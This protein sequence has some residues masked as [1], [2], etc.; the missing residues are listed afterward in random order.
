MSV[1][2]G[3]LR[4][5]AA[6]WGACF[7]LAVVF[8][9]ATAAALL[10]R[11][12]DH[13]DALSGAPVIMVDLAPMAVSTQSQQLDLAPGP[14][15]T[16]AQ[17]EPEPDTPK[18][19][20]ELLPDKTLDPIPAEKPKT[21]KP[22]EKKP[23]RQEASLTTAPVHTERQA[24]RAQT[25]L[26]G[27]KADSDALPNWKSALVAALERQ[28]RY[29]SEAQSRGEYGVA[30]LAFSVDR[31]GQVH[32]ARIVRSSGSSILDRET[33]ALLARAQPLPAPPH[34]IAG[35][36]IAVVVPIRYSIR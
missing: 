25:P 29:P 10:A 35:S 21:E 7:G 13:S 15:Q 32:N 19:K 26:A 36:Q 33:L 6:R 22:K 14:V 9:A 23:K 11:W 8:H 18:E 30:Y 4:S 1:A 12:N 31:S 17:K 5:E 20:A 34:N 28:K 2:R 27:A 16:Q 3:I 24:E